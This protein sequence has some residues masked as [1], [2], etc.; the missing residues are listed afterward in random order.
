MKQIS[1]K[2]ISKTLILAII[3]S[4]ILFQGKALDKAL[5]TVFIVLGLIG[6]LPTIIN[7]KQ[8]LVKKIYDNRQE[9]NKPKQCTLVDLKNK[10]EDIIRIHLNHRITDKLHCVFPKSTWEWVEACPITNETTKGKGS[11]QTS[12]T[13]EYNF[14]QIQVDDYGRII[15][16]ML[17]IVELDSLIENSSIEKHAIEKNTEQIITQELDKSLVLEHE[18]QL[19][20]NQASL[21]N[22]SDNQVDN[23]ADI[24]AWYDLFGQD[25]LQEIITDLNAR[26]HSQLYIKEDGTICILDQG[27]EIV[28]QQL[29]YLPK[30]TTW[31]QLIELF[32]EN[33]LLATV[34]QDKIRLT[35]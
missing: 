18:F 27:L 3:I 20:E 32:K 9:T 12:N 2:T 8:A 25:T 17:K 19:E 23:Q 28:K 34:D 4:M 14:G 35:W 10:P 26:G 29:E 31:N 16:Q 22:P 5:L 30:Q 24:N 15:V 7:K 33:G 21:K 1:F 6:I 13:G 11:I